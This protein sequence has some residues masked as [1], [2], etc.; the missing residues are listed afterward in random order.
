MRLGL[1]ESI[2][3]AWRLSSRRFYAV[4]DL[5]I[6][7]RIAAF[8]AVFGALV[9]LALL[10]LAA[11]TALIGATGWAVAGVI[12]LCLLASASV[13][14]WR[15]WWATPNRLLAGSYLALVAGGVLMLLSDQ[16]GGYRELLLPLALFTACV[17]P[18]RRVV[19]FLVAFCVVV[20]ASVVL[21][22]S[23]DSRRADVVT[24]LLV[25]NSLALV[26]LAWA[27]RVRIQRLDMLVAG[28]RDAKLARRDP[29]TELDNRRALDEA[30][31]AAVASDENR[32][33]SLICFDV[34]GFK[35]VN[36]HHG[37][38]AGDE[39]LRQIA[40]AISG[41]IDGEAR[42][43]R[44]GGDEFVVLLPGTDA[45]SAELVAR[46]AGAAVRDAP[47]ERGRQRLSLTWGIAQLKGEMS[48][49]DLVRAADAQLMTA[50]LDAPARRLRRARAG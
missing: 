9:V 25:W 36:D 35:A 8:L 38:M 14:A 44:W 13:F 5:R 29:L 27:C 26:A 42:A 46:R 37:H 20:A 16:P 2:D 31:A 47:A 45:A 30:L 17:H 19:T 41:A 43:F 22:D 40:D 10:P 7:K 48:A 23:A 3:R 6:A 24:E 34:D 28:E 32:A 49:E 4:A 50:K 15:S 21:G 39:A 11:P 1:L 18:P 12:V 33:L